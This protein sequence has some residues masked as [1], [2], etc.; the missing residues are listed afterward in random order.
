MSKYIK[1]P[2][3]ELKIMRNRIMMHVDRLQCS[4][5]SHQ[6]LTG[7]WIE[8]YINELEKQLKEAKSE[9]YDDGK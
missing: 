9:E 8:I 1:D 7:D 4:E 3:G 2:T 5:N 6:R